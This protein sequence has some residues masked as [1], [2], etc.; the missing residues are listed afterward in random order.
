MSILDEETEEPK[1][2]NEKATDQGEKEDI[3][4]S[5]VDEYVVKESVSSSLRF[6]LCEREHTVR[7]MFH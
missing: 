6:F 5:T 7:V 3:D 4:F 2:A 1:N